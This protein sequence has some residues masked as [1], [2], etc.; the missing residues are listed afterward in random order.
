MTAARAPAFPAASATIDERIWGAAP[1]TPGP[2]LASIRIRGPNRAILAPLSARRVR[3]D[4]AIG[5]TAQAFDP[6]SSLAR[7]LGMFCA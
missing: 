6:V 3:F 4:S 5:Q 1:P 7:S 2:P